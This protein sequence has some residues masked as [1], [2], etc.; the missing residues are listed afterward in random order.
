M[1]KVIV[2]ILFILAFLDLYAGDDGFSL[3][4]EKDYK[5]AYESFNQKFIDTDGEPLYSYNLGVTSSKLGKRGNAV[6]FYIQALQRAP[7]LAEA[8]NNLDILAKEL[9]ITIPN[10][11]TEPAHAVDHILIIFFISIYFFSIL[12]SILSFY[13]D[14]KIK[15]ALV[16][17]FLIMTVSAAMYFM[18]YEEENKLSWAVAVSNDSLKSGPDES[19]TEIGKLKEGEIINIVSSSGSWYKVKSFQDNV[20]GWVKLNSI[21]AVMRGHI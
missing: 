7:K 9:G 19:L 11:L 1:K 20:E 21:R 2:S 3:Y 15:T 12:V 6:Y 5:G 4:L 16:P 13:P 8:K 10:V 14:W 17:V 18:K